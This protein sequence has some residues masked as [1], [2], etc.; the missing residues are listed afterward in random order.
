MFSRYHK[1]RK[2]QE[3][4]FSNIAWGVRDRE[5]TKRNLSFAKERN[6]NSPCIESNEINIQSKNKISLASTFDTVKLQFADRED[7]NLII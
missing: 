4:I 6:K 5:R 2:Q 7:K 3:H 1:T